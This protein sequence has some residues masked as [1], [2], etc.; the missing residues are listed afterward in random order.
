MR[1]GAMIY[2]IRINDI[3][4]GRNSMKLIINGDDFG[5]SEAN[6][7]GIIKAYKDGI[8]RST[9]MMT[10]MEHAAF[11]AGLM[12]KY[13]KLGVGLH[14]TLTMGKP[15]LKT[16]QTIVDQNG[17]F[18]K[19]S[20]YYKKSFEIDLEEIKAEYQAQM[21]RFIELTGKLP[22]H[23]DHHHSQ[24]LVEEAPA[25]FFELAKKYDLPI[26]NGYALFG[27]GYDYQKVDFVRD[28]Y[29]DNA[30]IEFFLEDSANLLSY[31]IVECMAHPGYL[32]N[33]MY[34]KSSYNLQRMKEMEILCDERV[35][36][37]VKENKIELV[38]F[39]DSKRK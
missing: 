19:Q 12:P 36:N 4:R 6:T 7:L 26:R 29:D 39:S 35:K 27:E 16:H 22:T 18:R 3:K 5:L 28:F 15:I 1:F 11:A 23:I 2:I 38:N 21:D 17:D 32:D 10:N 37:W 8:L 31:E 30:T 33:D 9:T 13:P 14:L 24:C 34:H 25:I 20:E